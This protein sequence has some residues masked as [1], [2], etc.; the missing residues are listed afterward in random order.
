MKYRLFRLWATPVCLRLRWSCG[1]RQWKE[2]GGGYSSTSGRGSQRH[3]T[4]EGMTV[5]M[6]HH[7]SSI[8]KLCCCLAG[9]LTL[10]FTSCMAQ[11]VHLLLERGH[12]PA[13]SIHAPLTPKNTPPSA[14]TGYDRSPTKNKEQTLEAKEKPEYSFITQ[15][16]GCGVVYIGIGDPF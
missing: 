15:G 10:S 11:T 7:V 4:G 5:P 3:W 14:S 2:P 9:I 6:S 12:I 8:F 16:K 1:G 13:N